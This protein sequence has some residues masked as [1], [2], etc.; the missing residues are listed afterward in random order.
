MAH[1]LKAPAGETDAPAGHDKKGSLLGL[2][3]LTALVVGSMIGGGIFGLPMNMA[4]AAAPGPLLIGWGITGIGMLMLALTFTLLARLDAN[5]DGGVYGY[6]REGFGRFMGFSSAWG[7]WISAWLGNLSYFILIFSTLGL[8]WPTLFGTGT[9]WAAVAGQSVLLWLYVLLLLSGVR[10]AAGF[11]LIITVAKLVPIIAFVVLTAVAWDYGV[12]TA[13][14]WGRQTTGT[15][16]WEQVR[17]MM[18]VTVWVFV[19]IEGATVY[20]QRARQ[21]KDISRATVVGFLTV[22]ALLVSVNLL[23]AGILSQAELADLQDPSMAGVLREAV[24]PW[25][26]GLVSVGLIV[27]VVGA[28]LAWMLLCA[29]ILDV[30]AR[31]GA[32]P[33]VL[34]KEN[35]HGTP[36]WAVLTTALVLQAAL[37]Y[38]HFNS[39]NYLVVILMAGSMILLPYLLSAVYGAMLAW[40]HRRD[41]SAGTKHVVMA[42]VAA[43][44]ALWL[45][46]A[47]GLD[48]LL[49]TA[50]F[51][52]PGLA[53]YAWAQ[54]ENG[55]PVLKSW[56]WVIWG[57]MAVAFV[58]AVLGFRQGW[59]AL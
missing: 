23:S 34:S 11:N 55:R 30:T 35:R 48:Y 45:V 1:P 27:S 29:E 22:I 44:Y 13:D 15:G 53:V 9:T 42:V 50:L 16:V 5:P 20:S 24:G 7:Y 12:F 51:Y 43:V 38:A 33:R 17:N 21:R 2:P 46:F 14:F 10:E 54:K 31:D 57:V 47:G 28:L 59:L 26:A 58:A 6:A 39:S 32:M 25:G 49:M 18:L 19:G 40:R 56:E 8:W 52:A 37:V 3:Q 4:Q 41:G 36:T